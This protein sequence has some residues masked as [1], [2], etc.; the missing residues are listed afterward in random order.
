MTKHIYA[1][2]NA[3]SLHLKGQHIHIGPSRIS[4]RLNAQSKMTANDS[5][6]KLIDALQDRNLNVNTAELLRELSS[7]N[8]SVIGTWIEENL[9]YET[10]LTKEELSL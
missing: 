4:L 5:D 1:S 7:G 10:L 6:R 9:S 8:H 3:L 2:A